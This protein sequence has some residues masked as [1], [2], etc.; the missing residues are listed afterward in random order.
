M[1]KCSHDIL[2]ILKTHLGMDTGDDIGEFIL[3]A[4]SEKNGE[5]Q[6]SKNPMVRFHICTN[7]VFVHG[8]LHQ[9]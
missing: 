8:F 5:T 2:S 9:T 3:V 4:L 7:P 1:R 6:K